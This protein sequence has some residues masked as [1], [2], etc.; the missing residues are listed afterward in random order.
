MRYWAAFLSFS[1][2]FSLSK[3]QSAFN[4]AAIDCNVAR[5]AINSS[6]SNPNRMEHCDSFPSNGVED[7]APLV[8]PNSPSG[9]PIS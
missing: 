7:T 6:P 5:L 9:T 8:F 2:T 4:V 1:I 3:T